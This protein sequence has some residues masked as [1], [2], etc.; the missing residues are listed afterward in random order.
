MYIPNPL[1][2]YNCYKYGHHES[3]CRKTTAERFAVVA[4]HYVQNMMQMGMNVK[5]HLNVQT[6]VVSIILPPTPA[7]CG[8]G[9]SFFSRVEENC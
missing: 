4:L 7:L 2:C 1:Q 5:I 9:R 3:K 8:N 6:V